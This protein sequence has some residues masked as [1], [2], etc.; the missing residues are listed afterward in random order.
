MIRPDPPTQRDLL[1]RMSLL[2]GGRLVLMTC[3]R[4]ELYAH[5]PTIGPQS[6]IEALA[7]WFRVPKDILTRHTQSL[8]GDNAAAQL[9]RVAAGLESRIVGEAQVLGQVRAAFEQATECSALDAELSALGRAAIRTGKRVRHEAAVAKGARSFAAIAADRVTTGADAADKTC[10]VV[11]SGQLAL[12]VVADLALRRTQRLS[13][14]G[15]NAERTRSMAA[16][17]GGEVVSFADLAG[18]VRV[19]DV[20]IVCTSAPTYIIDSAVVEIRRTKPL[21]LVDLSVPRNVDPG[22]ERIPGVEV[23]HLDEL[24]RG[25]ATQIE[26]WDAAGRI[27]QEELDAYRRWSR[28]REVA[29]FIAALVR[30]ADVSESRGQF[31]DRHALHRRIEKLKAEAPR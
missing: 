21:L 6:W 25:Q 15:R 26:A 1:S 27:V 8:F 7:N 18:A 14:S 13:V 9:L 16:R 3:E 5:K 23:V 10:L 12:E 2:A 30:A 24:V 28:E 4:F 11:G 29:P 31:V 17:F 22:L 19:A 20:V